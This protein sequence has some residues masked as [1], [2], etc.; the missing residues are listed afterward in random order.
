M[1]KNFQSV[2]IF[3][4]IIIIINIINSLLSLQ[5]EKNRP[6]IKDNICVSTYCTIDQFKSGECIIDNPIIKKKWINSIVIVEN[7]NGDIYLSKNEETMK[8]VFGTSSSNNEERIIYGIMYYDDKYFIE[9]N[10]V[11]SRIIKKNIERTE[12]KRITN[13]E[14]S[15]WIDNLNNFV[16][17][18]GSD[19]SYIEIFNLYKYTTDFIL[20]SPTDF[21]NEDIII[22]GIPT[23][24]YFLEDTLFLGVMTTI[25]NET[26]N[27]NFS[28]Y[29]YTFEYLRNEFNYFLNSKIDIEIINIEYANCFMVNDNEK[30][31]SCFYIDLE[32]NYKITLIKSE[33]DKFEI[34]NSI[35]I[36]KFNNNDGEKFY[37]FKGILLEN[38]YCIYSYYSGDKNNIPTFLFKKINTNDFSITDSFEDFP[39]VFLYDDYLF[40]N[41]IKHNDLVSINSKEFF[42]ISSQKDKETIIIAYLIFY[43]SSNQDKLLIRYFTIQLKEYYNMKILNGLKS[44]YY[45]KDSYEGPFLAL[46]LDFCYYDSCINSDNIISNAGL[47]MFSFINITNFDIDFIEYAFN[48]NRN[49]LIVNFTELFNIE[50]N[51][52]GYYFSY[53]MYSMELLEGITCFLGDSEEPFNNWVYPTETL[54][55]IMF[56]NYSFD[57][58]E[59]IS[60]YLININPPD[61]INEFNEYCDKINDTFGDKNDENSYN[62]YERQSI[63]AK[64]SIIIR[65]DLSDNCNNKNC[66]LC[67]REDRDYCIVC[68][69]DEYTIIEDE[70]YKY[71]KLKLCTNNNINETNSNELIYDSDFPSEYDSISSDKI[72]NTKELINSNEILSDYNSISN[73]K[74]ISTNEL[75]NSNEI[76]SDYNSISNE[77]IINTNELSNSNEILN[78]YN[79]ISNEKIISTNEL[80]NSNEILSDYNSISNNKIITTEELSNDKNVVTE[81]NSLNYNK[82]FYSDELSNNIIIQTNLNS[83]NYDQQQIT[84]IMTN[85]NDINLDDILNDKYKDINLSEE[86]IKK[87]YEEVKNKYLDKYNGNNTIINTG[88]VKIQISDIDSQKYSKEVSNIDLG[89]CGEILKNKYC[90]SKNDSLTILK[91]DIRLENETSTYVQYEIYEPNSKIL[92]TLEECTGTNVVID[93][94]IELNTEMESL[95]DWLSQSGYNLFDA[96][97]SFY[98]DICA[99]YTTQNGTD[100]L[101]YD[102]RMDIYQSTLNVSLCQDGCD[103]KTYD[104]ETKKAKCDCSIQTN[105]VNLD[106]SEV[107]FD[108]NEMLNDFY[109]T[110]DNSNFRVLKC[111]KLVFNFKIF[112]K[113][114][115]SIIMTIQLAIFNIL[116][117]I[118]IIFGSRKIREIIQIIIK[119]KYN[120]K[121]NK[122]QDI[123]R[124]KFEENKNNNNNNINSKKKHKTQIIKIKKSK[125]KEENLSKEKNNNKNKNKKKKRGNRMSAIFVNNLNLEKMKNIN[126]KKTS[127]DL[128]N[129]PP[130]RNRAK[131]S[132]EIN[133]GNSTESKIL[134]KV[135]SPKSFNKLSKY[136]IRKKNERKDDNKGKKKNSEIKN[137]EVYNKYYKKNNR[138]SF[139]GHRRP[140]MSGN[141]RRQSKKKTVEITGSYQPHKIVRRS[142]LKTRTNNQKNQFQAKDLNT[143]EL[144]SLEYEQ[145]IKLD[146]RTYCQ[147]YWSLLKKKHLIL[148]TFLPTNDYNLMSLKISLFLVSFSLYLTINTFFFNDE[149]MH[150]IYK[151][152]GVYNILSQIPQILYSSI[153][154]SFIN[155]LLKS[156]SLS[157]KNI[158]KIKQEKDMKNTVIKS[159]K[160]EKCIYIK[161]I[162]FFCLSLILMLFFWYFIS[163]FCAVYNNTQIILFKDTLISFSLSMLYPIGINLIPGIFRIPA[164]RAEKKNKKCL[165]SFSQIVALI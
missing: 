85:D 21:L 56:D 42:F 153:I 101:L 43:S 154:S 96:N 133:I 36:D 60:Y 62:F 11:Y 12:Q 142:S 92:L 20:I 147:Y 139:I 83:L 100:I 158:L 69:N 4:K 110:L 106:L 117:I 94:P 113:N 136:N 103:F 123:K 156:L 97:D 79:S 68:E 52:F 28:L 41:E 57:K 16:I 122:G 34:K 157:E 143:Q 66:I 7:T 58:Y 50:N 44:L 112:V 81:Y 6:I 33:V 126:S 91:L 5:C 14:M 152:S 87:L 102:R 71:G 150:K 131:Y 99:V 78:D 55:K 77:K 159:K 46:A 53:G 160:I 74:I 108:K 162:I 38:D 120:E 73:E 76:L 63:Y 116:I 124:V 119:N 88:N 89:E 23:L 61:S 10:G 107:K 47:I 35:N 67:L 141:I 1:K 145:A 109:E 164:L 27:Y 45:N 134:N 114:I 135:N 84:E 118:H 105:E 146:K 2:F 127:M 8:L 24:S 30:L 22:K 95:Y 59:F 115:G 140:T 15:F 29:K 155:M 51:I 65:E 82:L 144:N 37:F 149:T 111:Y 161:F 31:I 125:D 18:I 13:A 129:V 138:K 40:N 3:F 17:L 130:K 128:K 49:Y 163:C 9:S 80:S 137:V 70:S 90:K 19:N 86:Q 26:P 121:E 148:F 39:V 132:G 151:E 104:L 75:S 64:H 48:N 25:N 72:I 32:N 98:N 93:V 54:I 165:Y